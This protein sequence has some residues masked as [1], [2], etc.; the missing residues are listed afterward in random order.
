MTGLGL[1]LRNQWHLAAFFFLV[2]GSKLLLISHYGV[3]IPFWDQWDA[4]ALNLYQPYLEGT[5]AFSDLLAPHNEHRLFTARLF[6]LALLE[7]NGRIWDPILQM[8]VNA[9][10]HLI[11]LLMILRFLGKGLTDSSRYFLSLFAAIVYLVPFGWENSLMGIQS[12]FYLLLLFSLLCL[13]LTVMHPAFGMRWW[14]GMLSGL[15]ACLTLASGVVALLAGVVVLLL[16]RL[17]GLNGG[18]FPF[19]AVLLPLVLVASVVYFTPTIL[20]HAALKAHSSGQF[21]GAFLAVAAWPG[22]YFPFLV[23][24]LPFLLFVGLFL[25]GKLMRS[26]SQWFLLALGVWLFGQYA[27]LAYGRA[28]G[29]DAS[30]YLDFFSIGLL[31]N[32]ACA[33]VLIRH[34]SERP[35][36]LRRLALATW[37]LVVAIGLSIEAA[38][39]LRSLAEKREVSLAS[40][41][42]TRA[43]LVTREEAHLLDKP[44]LHVPYP[45][46]ARLKGILDQPT[47][48]AIL[49]ANLN[50]E[51]SG[52][53]ATPLKRTLMLLADGAP[54]L[55]LLGALGFAYSARLSRTSGV[56]RAP[57]RR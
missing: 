31:L 11:V 44:Y 40:E 36:A 12:L 10:L 25:R 24:Q 34:F 20:G 57:D 3:A 42:N 33:A 21:L 56:A 54:L 51:N 5:L 48:R 27:L 18:R 4:E 55:L 23:I 30:R 43:Y 2:L 1:G 14:L 46:S 52:R 29:H 49:P 13:W 38:P 19:L 37:L 47:I 39:M 35:I 8:Q 15:V 9:V 22:Q 41:V 45:N 6:L 50:P 53:A 28:V 26:E 17:L 7:L 32:A 16:R